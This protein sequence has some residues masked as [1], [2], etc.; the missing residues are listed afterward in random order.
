MGPIGGAHHT[1]AHR[2]DKAPCPPGQCGHRSDQISCCLRSDQRTS[3]GQLGHQG[4]KKRAA[5]SPPPPPKSPQ[6]MAGHQP[7]PG[8]PCPEVSAGSSGS[9]PPAGRRAGRRAHEPPLPHGLLLCVLW[10][11]PWRQLEGQWPGSHSFNDGRCA[12]SATPMARGTRGCDPR[13]EKEET[14]HQTAYWSGV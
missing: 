12:V 2:A 9:R 13:D 3:D 6:A 5:L 4:K 11:A 1:V 14:D 7:P 10:A 8:A